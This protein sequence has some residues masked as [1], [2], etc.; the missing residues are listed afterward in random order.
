MRSAIIIG[1]GPA[2]LTA[3]RVLRDNGV[4]DVLV[5]ERGPA[6][7][8]LPQFCGHPGWGLFD[9]KRLWTGPVYAKR[10]LAAAQGV[11][12]ATNVSVTALGRDGRLTLA[13]RSGVETLEGRAVLLATGIRETPRSARLV[14]GT[15][16][17][18]VTTTGAFQE[19]V[20]AGGM[21][22]FSRPLIVGSELV[23]FSAIMTARHAGIRPVALIEPGNRIVARRPADVFSKL[24]WGVPVLTRTRLLSIHGVERVEG[25]DIETDGKGSTLA[26]DG[27]I[28]T[29]QFTPEAALVHTSH[30]A[31]DDRT[32]GP[33]ID[34]AWRCSD[35]AYFA[36]GNILRPVEHSGWAA[37]EG[38]AAARAIIQALEGR[39]PAREVAIP[40]QAQGPLR[41]VY[42]QRVLP[43][44]GKVRLFAR[45]ARPHKG[46]LK[47]LRDQ[48]VI[49]YRTIGA[50]PERRLSLDIPAER[51]QGVRML[52]LALD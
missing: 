2:G 6:C 18:G 10:L 50:L 4:R 41:Y 14:S 42:P 37:S 45:A 44:D 19:M 21:R 40:V 31:L 7:G 35:P 38:Q 33:M 47:L 26:C 5:L 25:V 30:L 22:P 20:Y 32:G 17:W 36:A 24:V 3:A 34:S 9:F 16:P 28:F 8:G 43:G 39:L 48:E 49:T 46:T 29:G 15:R 11:E 1:A 13:T 27:V 51:L 12:I 52:T 23:A